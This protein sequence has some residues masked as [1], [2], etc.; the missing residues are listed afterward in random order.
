MIRSSLI[1]LAVLA[2]VTGVIYPAIVTAAGQLLFPNAANGSIIYISEKAAGSKW[3]GQ[4]FTSNHYFWGRPSETPGAPYS[5]FVA[6][7]ASGSSGSNLGPTNPKL[8][9]SVRARAAN[10]KKANDNNNPVPIDLVTASAS[11]LD[12]DISMEGARY[13]ALRVARARGVEIST[14]RE[15]IDRVAEDRTWGLLGEPRV[16]VLLLNL[17][18]DKTLRK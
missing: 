4:N 17:E 7:P 12:P 6:D 13:Q 9:E 14:I 3:I 11:G 2:F 10:L 16:N 8:I 15:C 5:G 18:L 1:I